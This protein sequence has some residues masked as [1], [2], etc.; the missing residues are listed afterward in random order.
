MTL[1]ARAKAPLLLF[2]DV[3]IFYGSLFLTLYIR[4]GAFM[5][6]AAPF[7]IALG[8]WI[9]IF[10]I[11]GLYENLAFKN[12][13]ELTRRYFSLLALGGVFLI[14]LLYFVPDFGIAPKGN[15][16]IFMAIYAVFGF[17]WRYLFNVLVRLRYG[18][19]KNRVMF[20]GDN[21]SVAEIREY[22]TMN[23]Q[24]GYE[25]VESDPSIIVVAA[26]Q[27]D[28]ATLRNL[29]AEFLSGVDVV[30][31]TDFYEQIFAKVPVAEIDEAWLLQ[32]VS[33]TPNSYQIIGYIIES[34]L[35]FMLAIALLPLMIVV[36]LGVKLTSRGPVI[37]KQKRVG[38]YDM[39]FNLYKFRSMYADSARNPD[40]ESASPTWSSEKDTRVTPFG[41]FLR[42]SHIDE[43]PQLFNIL[44]GSMSFIGPRPERP[45]FTEKLEKEIP[46]YELRNLL[47]PGITGW[48]QLKYKY[49]SSV[50]DAYHKLQYDIYYVK[51]R[52]LALDT[53]IML[54]TFKKF[55][56]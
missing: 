41:K 32:N 26:R 38:Q 39:Q 52:S 18:S 35:A 15:F 19:V 47:K 56:V 45:E 17:S 27:Y 49:G 16:F 30:R 24:L 14:L 37:Y 11:G 7:T 20:I 50:E 36:A 42:A 6:H 31:L 3:I 22:L 25:I 29:Y 1:K 34:V 46:Y 8:A 9:L 5:A 23:R 12:T 13:P 40:A 28:P 48:A 55:F 44:G 51:N 33:R 4:D 53:K 54:K 10:F 2:G 43:F 21:E